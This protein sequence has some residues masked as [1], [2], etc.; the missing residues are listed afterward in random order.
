MIATAAAHHYTAKQPNAPW[1]YRTTT[2]HAID[3]CTFLLMSSLHPP[4]DERL[5]PARRG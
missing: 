3:V 2:T 5:A 1:L 4:H